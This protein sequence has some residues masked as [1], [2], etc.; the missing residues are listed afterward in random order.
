M[1][2][3]FPALLLI[4]CLIC[5]IAAAETD[6]EVIEI[7][8]SDYEGILTQ[9]LPGKIVEMDNYTFKY[10]LPDALTKTDAEGYEFYYKS[11]DGYEYAAQV[12]ELAAEYTNDELNGYAKSLSA[13]SAFD[14][15]TKI[16]VNG[17]NAVIF[18]TT[19]ENPVACCSFEVEGGQLMT[20]YFSP[21]GTAEDFALAT[22]FFAGIQ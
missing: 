3:L 14:R 15:V 13:N 11:S 8:W 6:T 16:L 20:F 19:G 18:T 2:R 22:A 7:N 4:L 9:N 1:K 12:T 17:L 21:A 10:Y 5:G